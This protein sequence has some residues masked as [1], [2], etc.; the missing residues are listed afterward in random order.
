MEKSKWWITKEINKALVLWVYKE[1]RDVIYRYYRIV[2]IS[3]SLEELNQIDYYSVD[4]SLL[5]HRNDT[6]IWIVWKIN[7]RKKDFRIKGVLK[8]DS[9]TLKKFITVYV[10][11]GSN[12]VT[13]QW[14][15]YYFLDRNN[16]GYTYFTHNHGGRDFGMGIES[17]SY[18]ETLWSIL[19][20]KNKKYL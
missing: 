12:I 18:I 6:Q 16:S 5:G 9:E 1:I 19:K 4:K 3:E 8:S 7:I 15:G 2:Y 20:S 10:P 11:N 13:D 17:T 14:V